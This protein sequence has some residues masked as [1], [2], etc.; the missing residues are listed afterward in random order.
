MLPGADHN[1]LKLVCLASLKV[2][3]NSNI[4][5]QVN[6]HQLI[7]D[8]EMRAGIAFV[9]FFLCVRQPTDNSASLVHSCT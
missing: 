1:H 9:Y 2:H 3:A 8:G 5:I 7:M 4:N 6:V